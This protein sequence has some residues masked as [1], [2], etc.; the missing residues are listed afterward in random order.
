M[1]AGTIA[2]SVESSR[3][4]RRW[5]R[6]G[7]A[8]RLAAFH[9]VI[10][11]IALGA[12]TTVLVNSFQASY[13]R[14]AN[15]GLAAE[16]RSFAAAAQRSGAARDVRAFAV[17]Y[18]ATRALPAGEVAIV[19]LGRAVIATPGAATLETQP[20]LASLLATPPPTSRQFPLSIAGAPYE[21][22]AV[23]IRRDGRA[24]GTFAV[25]ADLS[26]FAAQRR[27][28]LELSLLEG[29]I[30]LAVGVT[31]AFVLLRRL[32][33]TVGQVTETA[34]AISNGALGERLGGGEQPDEVG[35][36][37]RTFD[38]MLERIERAM[39]A[40]RRLLSDVSHQLRTPLTVARGHL[41]VLQRTGA[42]DPRA[43]EEAVALVLDEL[44]HMA[45]LIDRLLLLGRAMEPDF[46][47]EEPVAL[48][49][50]FA[51]LAEAATVLGER[52]FV[53]GATVPLELVA[54]AH[55][56]RGALLNLLDNA[57]RATAPGDVIALAAERRA[58]EEVALIVEDSGPGIPAPER[59][60]ALER[61]ARPG[62]RDAGGSG[63]GL[64]IAK[65]VAE[66]HGGRLSISTSGLGGA[67]VAIVLPPW[68]V[69][70]RR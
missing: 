55:K 29:A 42:G 26:G 9:L 11:F 69:A 14:V 48:S 31:S 19:S 34:E 68:R 13:E 6:I 64:A 57:V 61:F 23:P 2:V 18:L 59:D 16:A 8:G 4:R 17:S 35:Q 49:D 62:A 33:R 70:S 39:A 3:P 27:H 37:E 50:L 7:S 58:S 32:L 28:V 47:A 66:A 43:S 53:L 44:V 38:A 52:C 30:V 24:L 46:L 67:R 40:Q 1:T 25:A 21:V 65:A 15:A 51:E 56:L 60:L 5:R 45:A 54:D 41:E 22:L 12:L 20:G 63:L 10:L 36:L